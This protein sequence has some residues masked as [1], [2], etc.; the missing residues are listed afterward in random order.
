MSKAQVHDYQVSECKNAEPFDWALFVGKKEPRR[1]TKS[2][3]ERKRD[4]F[5]G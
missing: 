4:Q 5:A 1:D 3:R 2:E